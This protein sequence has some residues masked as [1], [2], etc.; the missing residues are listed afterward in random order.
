MAGMGLFLGS[1]VSPVQML[2]QGSGTATRM[3]AASFRDELNQYL[4][5][6]MAQVAQTAACNRHHLSGA[7]PACRLLMT[8]DR[9]QSNE[10]HLTQEFL[11]HAFSIARAWSVLAPV[12]WGRQRYSRQHVGLGSWLCF[13]PTPERVGRYGACLGMAPS[14]LPALCATAH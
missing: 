5:M 7:R 8:L 9:A 3:K 10:F 13:T 6:F 14:F 2:V 4:Y 11:A 1:S 12:L